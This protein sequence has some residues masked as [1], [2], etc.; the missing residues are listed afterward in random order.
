MTIRTGAAVALLLAYASASASTATAQELSWGVNFTSNYMSDSVTQSDD[1]PA[2]QGYVEYGL[3]GF[4]AGAW[5]STVDF[6]PDTDNL[7]LDLYFGFR[8]EIGAVS[9]DVGYARYFYDRTGDCCGE[10]LASVDAEMGQ[11]L[12]LGVSF[13]YN[14]RDDELTSRLGAALV[15]DDRLKVSGAFGRSQANDNHFWDLGVGYAVQPN[16]GLDVRYH[17]TTN[18][19]GRAVVSLGVDF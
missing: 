1:K 18:T 8:N 16:V 6:G 3:D 5:A 4:Y 2:L 7:E 10:F 17:D 19:R 13:A 9:Y 11:G 12:S 15:P 14:N